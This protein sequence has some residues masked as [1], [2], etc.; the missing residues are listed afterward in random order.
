MH[1][2]L[3][4]LILHSFVAPLAHCSPEEIKQGAVGCGLFHCT[5]AT[6]GEED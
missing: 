1:A 4:P 3:F 5:S 2:F 6:V